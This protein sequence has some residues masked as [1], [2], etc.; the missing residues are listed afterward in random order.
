MFQA[1]SAAPT[2]SNPSFESNDVFGFEFPKLPYPFDKI[3]NK[4]DE[5]YKRIECARDVMVDV[6]GEGEFKGDLKEFTAEFK[7]IQSKYSLCEDF[8]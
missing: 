6:I 1:V 4:V 8:K 5:I 3:M 2:T 7:R